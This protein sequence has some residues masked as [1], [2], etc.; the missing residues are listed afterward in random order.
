MTWRAIWAVP[1]RS[2]ALDREHRGEK[3]GDGKRVTPP[4][5]GPYTTSR[6]ISTCAYF[7]VLYQLRIT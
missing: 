6:V 4:V 2:E 5:A 1:Y 7:T 3:R